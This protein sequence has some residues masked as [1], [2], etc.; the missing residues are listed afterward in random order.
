MTLNQ[1]ANIVDGAMK[2]IRQQNRGAQYKRAV[3]RTKTATS[4]IE[5]RRAAG[6]ARVA[7]GQYV[8]SYR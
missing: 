4:P 1:F 7:W 5:K 8:K 2:P 6:Q 3:Q